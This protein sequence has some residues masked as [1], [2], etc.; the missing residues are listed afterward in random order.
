LPHGEHEFGTVEP[1]V[2]CCVHK[3]HETGG[4]G[5]ELVEKLNF[6]LLEARGGIQ[7]TSDSK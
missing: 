1:E 2:S 7:W 6:K 3:P 5:R 4:G